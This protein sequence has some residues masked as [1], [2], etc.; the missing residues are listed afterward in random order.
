MRIIAVG[1]STAIAVLQLFAGGVEAAEKVIGLTEL[2]LVTCAGAPAQTMELGK[3]RVYVYATGNN[4][5]YL[6]R[7]FNSYVGVARANTCQATVIFQGGRVIK[8]TY[9][10]AGALL[11]REIQCGKLFNACA[12]KP[13]KKKP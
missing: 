1:L 13:T 7:A 10:K 3:N 12:P 11:A 2:E 9:Q 5:V 8:V 6:N 4:S